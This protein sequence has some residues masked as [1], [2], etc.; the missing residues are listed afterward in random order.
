MLLVGYG[1]K[2]TKVVA[3]ENVAPAE[4]TLWEGGIEINWG[5]ANVTVSAADMA[6]VPVGATVHVYYQM[7]DMPDGF[8]GAI[9]P[10]IRS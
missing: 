1:Y 4:T 6:A 5:D 10:R 9:M 8:G 3:V 2:L 7:A